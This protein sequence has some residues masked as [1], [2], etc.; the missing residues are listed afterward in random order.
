MLDAQVVIFL[1]FPITF[2]LSFLLE[3]GDSRFLKAKPVG[4]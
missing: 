3:E 2:Q 4:A 1:N